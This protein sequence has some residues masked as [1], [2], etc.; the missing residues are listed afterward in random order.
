M[1][2][3]F[4]LLTQHHFSPMCRRTYFRIR[5]SFIFD[6]KEFIKTSLIH[7]FIFSDD[8]ANIFCIFQWVS[9]EGLDPKEG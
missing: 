8:N 7:N 3:N 1:I 4:E 9:C 5:I 6:V 2:K